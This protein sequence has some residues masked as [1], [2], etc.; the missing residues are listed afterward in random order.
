MRSS[1][2]APGEANP[3]FDRGAA[4]DVELPGAGRH[5]VVIVT[6]E[7]AIPVRS[8]LTVAIV[9]STVRGHPAEVPVG[10]EEGLRRDRVVNRDEL[11]TVST[12]LLGRRRGGLGPE[13]IGRLDEALRLSAGARMACV[14]ASV[15]A[16]S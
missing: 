4:H 9:T 2:I 7:S 15:R 16:P 13:R 12:D 3:I 11:H 10:R 1:A 5:P 6:R 14:D 8:A